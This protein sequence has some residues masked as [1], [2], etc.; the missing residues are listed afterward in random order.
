[1][2]RVRDPVWMLILLLIVVIDSG[3]CMSHNA[4]EESEGLRQ[5][6]E[7]MDGNHDGQVDELEAKRY[8]GES[9]G[10]AEF[11]SREE[12][13][14]AFNTMVHNMNQED[15]DEAINTISR[16]EVERHLHDLDQVC[17]ST[18]F[19]RIGVW[20]RSCR[21]RSGSIMDWVSLNMLRHLRRT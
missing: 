3:V 4:R 11:D 12:L 19:G 16:D 21:S 13:T 6:F 20:S 17:W 18:Y 5:F 1:M 9:I 7:E 2:F 14:E 10:G 8:I 15:E